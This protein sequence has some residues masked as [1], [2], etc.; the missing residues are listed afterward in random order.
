V[1]DVRI[2]LAAQGVDAWNR[3]DLDWL[4]R[5]ATADFEF[6]PAVAATVEGGSVKG[7]E[8]LARFFEAMDESW[9]SFRIEVEEFR[10][11]GDQ[12]VGRGRVLA[13]GRGSGVE[14][15]QPLGSLLSF[16][17]DK[18]ARLQSYLDPEEALAA[19][20]SGGEGTA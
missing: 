4:R 15:D 20:Q 8:G 12:V 18:I 7:P 13:K 3:R 19:A 9:E 14:L 11:I 2:E 5:N 6:V 1:S 17:G 10:L 16:E